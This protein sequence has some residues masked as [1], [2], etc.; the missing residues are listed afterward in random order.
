MRY[1]QIMTGL[2][3][4]YMPDSSYVFKSDTRK[5]LK[6]AIEAECFDL[7]DAGMIGLSKR[8]TTRLASEV[9]RGKAKTIYGLS[10]D[11]G[12]PEQSGKPYNLTVCEISRDEFREKESE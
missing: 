8:H 6:R 3:G 11:Y 10:L 7:R 9:W 1:F 4:C 12:S 2:G 5:E